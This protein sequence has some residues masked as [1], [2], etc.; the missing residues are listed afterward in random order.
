M[1]EELRRERENGWCNSIK[2]PEISAVLDAR[3]L[4]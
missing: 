2:R 3:V 4:I 1:I